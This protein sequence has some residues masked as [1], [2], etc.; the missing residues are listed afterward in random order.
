MLNRRQFL[1]RFG[2]LAAV[3]AIATGEELF[4]SKTTQ[5]IYLPGWKAVGSAN[6]SRAERVLDRLG[7][8]TLMV[9][10]KD[11]NGEVF[12]EAD[13]KIGRAL[14]ARTAHGHRR[15]LNFTKLRALQDKGIRVLG[16]HVM[17]RDR[18]LYMHS[19]KLRLHQKRNE[20]WV[21]PRLEG[22][23]DYNLELLGQ[24]HDICFDEIVLDYIRFP[25][26][27]GFGSL[28]KKCEHIDE[29]VAE[30]RKHVDALGVQVFGWA[31]WRHEKAGVGQ[32]IPT[33]DP[34]ID[35]VYPMVYPSHFQKGS[36][37][38]DDPNEH[39]GYILRASYKAAIKKVSRPEKVVP[40]VQSFWYEPEQVRAQ[41]NAVA[42]AEMSGYVAWNAR[43]SYDLLERAL[44][45]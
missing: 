8:N 20:Y 11:A 27:N 37:G 25:A 44:A 41:L 3:P 7:L 5:G 31:A 32:R 15:T 19:E 12:F 22:A 9:D 43:G 10:L 45:I 39:P 38:F 26:V 42:D 40:M 17:F 4:P 2:T 35:H 6:L 33:L 23:L 16:R 13:N 1:G 36:F 30:A 21:D 14:Q 28:E 18:G 34:H 29:V 24:S